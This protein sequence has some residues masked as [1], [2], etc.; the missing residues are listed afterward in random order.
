MRQER[1]SLSDDNGIDEVVR[2]AEP[3][4]SGDVESLLYQVILSFN[5]GAIAKRRAAGK[6]AQANKSR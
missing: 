1:S 4:H 6:A 3:S 5:I 2:N